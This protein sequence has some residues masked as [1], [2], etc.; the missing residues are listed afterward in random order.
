MGTIYL[1]IGMPKTGTSA[2]QLFLPGNQ[3]LLNA[4]GYC[5]P[6]M[7]FRF[8]NIGI[9][10]NAH[11]LTLWQEKETAPEWEKGFQVVAEAAEQYENVILSDENI[12]TRQREEGF[13]E[14]VLPRLS[15]TG[16]DV[17]VIVYLR[18]QD[19]QFES[20]WNQKVKDKK[21]RMRRSFKEF[22]D[23][24]GYLEMPFHYDE[25]LDAMSSR[26]GRERIIVRVYEK[27]QF[28]GGSLF[29]DFLETVGLHFTEEY[30]LPGYAPNVR[31]SNTAVEIKRLINFAFRE[32]MEVPDFY[33]T[34]LDQ[35]Y[36]LKSIQEIPEQTSSMFSP[37]MRRDFMSRYEEGNK[38]VA[39][40]YFG[41]E[42]GRLFYDEASQIPQWKRDDSEVL[43]EMIRIFA[44]EGVLLYKR[45]QEL[46]KRERQFEKKK[47]EWEARCEERLQQL[48]KAAEEQRVLAGKVRELYNSLP[49]RMYRKVR[50]RRTGRE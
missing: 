45:T 38:R 6:Q 5:Y 7:P 42:D 11:F 26:I 23:D 49:F 3:E 41:R 10:R 28:T 40:E 19:E 48:E 16:A 1:H 13:W 39:R 35:V 37:E 47:K 9:R 29:E 21:R 17:R 8:K 22:Y 30:Q 44:S 43:T 32:N 14:N 18:R 15:E 46:D 12:W 24:E 27:G 2:L 33:R 34:I 4:R 25:L 50:P 31:L 36:E 20:N